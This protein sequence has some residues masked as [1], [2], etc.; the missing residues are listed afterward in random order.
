MLFYRVP[1][2]FRKEETTTTAGRNVKVGQGQSHLQKP[3]ITVPYGGGKDFQSRPLHASKQPLKGNVMTF[4]ESMAK[5][6]KNTPDR[7]RTLPRNK[8]PG[9]K[10]ELKDSKFQKSCE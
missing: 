4:A 3:K 9:L 7:F 10:R 6:Q 5:F 8:A 1:S 2:K